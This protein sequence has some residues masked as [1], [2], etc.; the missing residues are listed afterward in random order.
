MG[1]TRMGVWFVCGIYDMR[2]VCGVD[3]SLW[4]TVC[5]L[6]MICL[7]RGYSLCAV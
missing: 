5:G 2:V 4:L 7:W 3:V 1:V 6:C